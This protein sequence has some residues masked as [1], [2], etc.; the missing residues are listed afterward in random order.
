MKIDNKLE[1][2]RFKELRNALVFFS[3]LRTQEIKSKIF[4]KIAYLFI[5]WL[6]CPANF[7]AFCRRASEVIGMQPHK[8]LRSSFVLRASIRKNS[9]KYNK[10]IEGRNILKMS[11]YCLTNITNLKRSYVNTR[12]LNTATYHHDRP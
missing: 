7:D 12:L 6:K 10:K 1:K 2:T 8:C 11:V 9:Y 4:N 5:C 3:V